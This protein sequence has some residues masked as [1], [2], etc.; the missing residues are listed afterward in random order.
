MI[1][2]CL[3]CLTQQDW[4]CVSFFLLLHF[5]LVFFAVSHWHSSPCHCRA[6]IHLMLLYQQMECVFCSPPKRAVETNRQ[7]LFQTLPSIEMI[8]EFQLSIL[9]H[10]AFHLSDLDTCLLTFC[11]HVLF[12]TS[13]VEIV[14][15]V[16]PLVSPSRAVPYRQNFVTLATG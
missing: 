6:D 3:V 16:E 11:Q 5:P 10:S 2:F 15:C 1:F 12:F 9:S 4:M 7:G 8:L 14:V 13:A